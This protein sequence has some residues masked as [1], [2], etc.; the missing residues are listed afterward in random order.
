[1][2]RLCM[3]FPAELARRTAATVP[4]ASAVVLEQAGHMA[5]V[6]QPDQWLAAIDT[7]LL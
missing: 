6:D 7:F 5:H 2:R 4:S 3:T 1:M